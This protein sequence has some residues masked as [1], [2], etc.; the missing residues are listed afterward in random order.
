[1]FKNDELLAKFKQVGCNE[2][3]SEW[4]ELEYDNYFVYDKDNNE[5]ICQNCFYKFANKLFVGNNDLYNFVVDNLTMEQASDIL[6]DLYINNDLTQLECLDLLQECRHQTTICNL[7]TSYV[8]NDD[9]LLCDS[10][11][12]YSGYFIKIYIE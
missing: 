1:M 11:I 8:L 9:K 10:V 2:C 3:L 6:W 12:E 7:I 4:E 5:F